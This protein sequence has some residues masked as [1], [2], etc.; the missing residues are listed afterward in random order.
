MSNKNTDTVHNAPCVNERSTFL[1]NPP[2]STFTKKHFPF[3]YK[4]NHFPLLQK[5]RSFPAYGL[6]N[7]VAER[8][9]RRAA[10]RASCATEVD[11]Q[12]DKVAK[13]VGRTRWAAAFVEQSWQHVATIDALWRNFV[14][15]ES[16]TKIQRKVLLFLEISEFSYN[17][18]ATARCAHWRETSMPKPSSI[19]LDVSTEHQLVT[20]RHR[21]IAILPR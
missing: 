9:A 19:H 14:S 17:T 12:S 5:T 21:A 4:K 6:T 15:A 1:Q 16:G 7:V 10:S 8:P 13:L 20:D 3:F 2:F 11:D 18:I